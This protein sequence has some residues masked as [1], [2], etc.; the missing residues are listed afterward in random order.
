[1]IIG[2]FL[3]LFI[4]KRFLFNLYELIKPTIIGLF[5]FDIVYQ[6]LFPLGGS[7]RCVIFHGFPYAVPRGSEKYIIPYL[8][9]C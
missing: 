4:T 5:Y 9:F 7:A 3:T 1:M 2:I 8:L 6:R